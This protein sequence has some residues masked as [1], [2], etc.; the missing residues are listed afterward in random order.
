MIAVRIIAL[1]AAGAVLHAAGAAAPA[2][3]ERRVARSWMRSM[4]LRDKAAQL[5]IAEFRGSVPNARSK[6]YREYLSLVRDLKVGG[7]ALVNRSEPYALA[8]FLNRM[9]RASKVPLL[10]GGDFERAV[11]MRVESATLFPHAMAFAAAGSPELSRLE[12]EITARQARALGVPWIFAPV[13][14]VNNNPDNPII[15]IRS[16]GESP[17]VVAAHVRAF[18]EGARAAG[19]VLVTVKHFPGHGDT[20]TDSHM[21]LPV[22]DV[23]KERLENL[24]LLPF[25]AAIEAGVDAVMSAHIA[26]PALDKD[27]ATLSPALLTGVLQKEL[28]FDGLIVTDALNMRGITNTWPAGEAAVRALEAGVDVL[29]IPDDPKAAVDGIVAAVRKGRLSEARLNHSVEK[30]LAAK[31]RVGLDRE[32]ITDPEALEDALDTP[33]DV[34]AAQRVAD[35]AVTLVK[36]DN[37]LLPLREPA[38]TCFVVLAESRTTQAGRLFAAE[39][40]KR[41]PAA[42]VIT[43]DPQAP[44]AELDAAVEKAGSASTIVVAAFVSVASY[45]GSVALAGAYP[46]LM[47]ALIDTDKPVALIALGSPYLARSFP[48]VAAYLT[49]YSTV[50]TS[51]AAAVKALFGEMPIQGRLPVTIPGFAKYGDGIQL[52]A[53]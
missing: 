14:D 25:R 42:T 13:A 20:A 35:Q 27:P 26:V 47:E 6:A 53:K 31:V 7:F 34:E 1:L 12:G 40:A 38:G 15:N 18:I 17:E 52:P 37:D 5:V 23:T 3:R 2:P 30:L 8:A 24:E 32:R 10:V 33:E 19:P 43:L 46:K 44:Q 22:L 16:Y 11:S 51:E 28:G 21:E 36:N 39:V 45:R 49:T 41:A 29:L 4:T 9:Q 48:R 50:P